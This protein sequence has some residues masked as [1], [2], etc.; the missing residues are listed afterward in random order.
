P[1]LGFDPVCGRG[2]AL[3]LPPAAAKRSCAALRLPAT[4]QL[5]SSA[6]GVGPRP[7]SDLRPSPPVPLVAPFFLLLPAPGRPGL[8]ISTPMRSVRRILQS[9][10]CRS[11]RIADAIGC[12]PVLVSAR[13]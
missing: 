4:C 9:D 5:R 8:A 3:P 6:F 11:D 1:R 7:S 2:P 10:P 12:G 13:L